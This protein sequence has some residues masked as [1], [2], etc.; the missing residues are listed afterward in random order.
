MPIAGLVHSCIEVTVMQFSL[1]Q[2]GDVQILRVKEP[3]LTYPVLSSFFA[4]VQRIVDE[5]ARKIVIDLEPVLFIDSPF[6]GCLMDIRRLLD[7]RRG[8]LKLSGLH[9]RL[10][11][12]LSLTG[13]DRV[14][15][16]HG[17]EAAAVAAF[18]PTST[19][20]GGAARAAPPTRST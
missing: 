13:V 18:G 7:E 16:L 10:H 3:K 8:V 19:E 9:P 2:R 12:M 6:I 20:P 17:V 4:E 1:A 11:T 5:G 14:V 15:E